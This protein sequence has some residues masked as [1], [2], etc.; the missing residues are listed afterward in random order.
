MAERSGTSDE[1]LG[2]PVRRP[3]W[4]RLLRFCVVLLMYEAAAS[5]LHFVIGQPWDQ[6]LSLGAALAIGLF[7]AEW[8]GRRLGRPWAVR[9]RR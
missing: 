1:A 3:W 2:R 6:A 9:R 7:I 8:V 4:R 5:L